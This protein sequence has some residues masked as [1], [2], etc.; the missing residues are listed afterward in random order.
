[1]KRFSGLFEQITEYENLWKAYLNARKGKRYRGEVLEFTNNLEE[2]LRLIQQ[3]LRSKAY[4]IGEYREFYLHEPK[5]RLIVALPF[6]DRV[7]QWAI[8]LILE[9]LLDKQFIKDSYACRSGKGVQKAADRV[10]YWQRQLDR[11]C[12][13]PYYLKMDIAKFFYRIDQKVILKILERKIKDKELLWLLEIIIRSENT[14]FGVP[15]DDH[16]FEQERIEGIGIPIGNLSSQLM[17][18]LY[19]NEVDQYVKHEMKVRHYIRYMDD[20][21]ILHEDK[22]ELH[23][24][25]EEIE[26]FLTYELKLVLNNKTVIRPIQEGTEYVGMRI[27]P[28]HR[29]LSKPTVKKMK[30]RLK[31]IQKA[32]ARGEIDAEKARSVLASYVGLMKHANCHNLKKKILSEFV[33]QRNEVSTEW[34]GGDVRDLSRVD[35]VNRAL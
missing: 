17:A 1:M 6:R 9:P 26:L 7:I 16:E 25:L 4:Q 3:D 11:S 27:W 20:M 34:G 15:L 8:Y 5:K 33:L 19:M 13:K 32:F 29:K 22:K 12:E 10:Q 31:Y 21:L 23:R 28:T 2:N 18:N 14:P 24:I 35:H 30:V